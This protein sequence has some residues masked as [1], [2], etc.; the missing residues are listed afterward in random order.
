MKRKVAALR[1]LES[2]CLFPKGNG[3]PSFTDLLVSILY[4]FLV[5]ADILLSI[6]EEPPKD[7]SK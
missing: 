6:T 4:T 7:S 1:S 2:F 3:L 5:I